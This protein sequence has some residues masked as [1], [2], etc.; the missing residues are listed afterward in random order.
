MSK[1]ILYLSLIIITL[2]FIMGGASNV[3]AADNEL[4]EIGVVGE[5]DASNSL[6]NGVSPASTITAQYFLLHYNDF[7][8]YN[9][10]E[11]SQF[12]YRNNCGITFVANVLSYFRRLGFNLYNGDIT[13]AMYDDIASLIDYSP[14]QGTRVYKLFNGIETYAKRAGYKAETNDYLLDLWSDVTRDIK[15]GYPVLAATSDHAYMVVGCR[16]IDGVKQLY[17]VTNQEGANYKWIN[18]DGAGLQMRSYNITY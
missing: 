17:V 14:S 1:K 4:T 2:C 16:I 6:E 3:Y 11:F 10:T 13:Q 7:R 5:I 15:L 18:F 9:P 8:V 12:Q